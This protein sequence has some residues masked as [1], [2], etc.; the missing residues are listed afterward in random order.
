[1][2]LSWRDRS[3][4]PRQR[5][6]TCEEVGRRLQHYLD[7]E[8]DE[9]RATRLA[10][11]L[12]DCRRCGLEADAYERIKQSLSQRREALP[13][14]ALERLRDFGSRLARGDDMTT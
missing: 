9:R 12:A 6:M 1:M 10:A 7:G 8:L 3:W 5:S 14:D 13:D 4:W 11:H 2:G